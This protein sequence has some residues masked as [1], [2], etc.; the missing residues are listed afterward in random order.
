MKS[1]V[2]NPLTTDCLKSCQFAESLH[3]PAK[4]KID[5]PRAKQQAKFRA[6]E[7]F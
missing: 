3:M 6:R 5:D 7:Y 2:T 1:L 4:K